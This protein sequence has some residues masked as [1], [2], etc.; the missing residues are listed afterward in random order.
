[1]I[2]A[3]NSK[4]LTTQSKIEMSQ[5]MADRASHEEQSA[6][7]TAEEMLQTQTL[8]NNTLTIQRDFTA[9]GRKIDPKSEITGTAD[10]AAT[11]QANK[12]SLSFPNLL[13]NQTQSSPVMNNSS[14]EDYSAKT[15]S[16]GLGFSG[17]PYSSSSQM[18][19]G[20]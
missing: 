4:L 12:Q 8:D 3:H 10:N 11:L 7:Q 14:N 19:S 16:K 20:D 18:L 1:M 13:P 5:V 15:K 17:L 2:K 6:V 9:S